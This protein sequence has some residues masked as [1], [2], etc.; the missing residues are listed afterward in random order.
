MKVNGAEVWRAVGD[1][2]VTVL[3]ANTRSELSI[4]P[5]LAAVEEQN[6]VVA[7][8]LAKTE[9]FDPCYTGLAP[10]DLSK[11]TEKYAEKVGN[12]TYFLH[13]DHNTFGR[14]GGTK[15]E[16]KTT[17][18]FRNQGLEHGY[19]SFSIDASYLPLERNLEATLEFARP[20]VEKGL[21]LEV[22]VGE[23]KEG[24]ISEVGESAYFVQRLTEED[25]QPH[26][27][28]INNGSKHGHYGE[29]EWPHIHLRRTYDIAR[30]IG[31]YGV[32]GIAQHGTSG[33]SMEILHQF[34][35]HE[36]KKANVATNFS[37][38]VYENLPRKLQ[39]EMQQWLKDNG[40][41]SIKYA[42]QAF[43]EQMVNVDKSYR[44]KIFDKTYQ[45]TKDYLTA[46][47]ASGLATRLG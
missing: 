42:F 40:K 23:I 18:E 34:P 35:E 45:R 6:S 1:V 43:K 31:Q 12:P 38:I 16:R 39:E 32:C 30:A 26:I 14:A 22:E 24:N 5:I 47:N 7:I 20:I 10:E 29:Q 2:P 46:F 19:S 3:A 37:D 15:E 33:T 8:E 25:I 21:G 11:L 9:S 13:E 41:S 4:K 27:L 17:I 44:E 28:A 36:I